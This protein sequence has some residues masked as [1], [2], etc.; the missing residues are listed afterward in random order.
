M[1]CILKFTNSKQITVFT[2]DIKVWNARLGCNFNRQIYSSFPQN[3]KTLKTLSKAFTSIGPRQVDVQQQ[4]GP[5]G[6]ASFLEILLHH[7][8]HSR[9]GNLWK[10]SFRNCHWSRRLKH[11]WFAQFMVL[12]YLLVGSF[13]NTRCGGG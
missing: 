13:Y 7:S 6:A 10:K 2:F 1:K 4:L 11:F 12:T 8:E 3:D 9:K 5:W